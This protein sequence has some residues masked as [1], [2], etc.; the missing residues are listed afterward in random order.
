M[1]SRSQ[2]I[3]RI[4]RLELVREPLVLAAPEDLGF[5]YV[6]VCLDIIILF[7]GNYTKELMSDLRFDNGVAVEDSYYAF[8]LFN[9]PELNVSRSTYRLGYKWGELD[10][11]KLSDDIA[12]MK[13]I[14]EPKQY[15]W[16]GP[17]DTLAEVKKIRLQKRFFD[18]GL[19]STL[20]DSGNTPFYRYQLTIKYTSDQYEV[21]Q[22][23]YDQAKNQYYVEFP[24]PRAFRGKKHFH[25]AFDRNQSMFNWLDI[26][27]VELYKER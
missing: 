21:E 19:D 7:Q 20:V 18:L 27:R 12:M 25:I 10:S 16:P 1:I 17:F 8:E 14:L 3:L 26:R 9:S 2:M 5:R 11:N 6:P 13:L 15:E 24:I 23:A 4:T 22:I